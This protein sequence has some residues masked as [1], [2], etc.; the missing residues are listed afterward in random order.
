MS[1]GLAQKLAAKSNEE[2]V[3]QK[4]ATLFLFWMPFSSFRNTYLVSK[5]KKLATQKCSSKIY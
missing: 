1:V 2:L 5:L 3:N 4:Y